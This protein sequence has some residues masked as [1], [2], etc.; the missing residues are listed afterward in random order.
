MVTAVAD[1][2]ADKRAVPMLNS[3]W[4]IVHGGKIELAEPVALPEGA[5]VLITTLPDGDDIFWQE[6]SG[7]A[8]AAAW[9]NTEDDVYAQLHEA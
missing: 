4:A 9:D 3:H 5:R 7:A 2:L 1:I 8:L 6:A